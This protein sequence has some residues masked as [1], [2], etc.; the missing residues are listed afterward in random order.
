MRHGGE[1]TQALRPYL[2]WLLAATIFMFLASIVLIPWLLVRIPADYF[3][4]QTRPAGY[5]MMRLMGLVIK[6]LIGC[7]LLLLGFVMLFIPGQGLLTLFA[8][9]LLINFPGKRRLELWLI[10]RSGVRKTIAWLRNKA[11][12]EPLQMPEKDSREKT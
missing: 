3:T 2:G 5:R 1:F 12:R 9:L 7:L 4:R 11:G 10:R 6:N 8:G